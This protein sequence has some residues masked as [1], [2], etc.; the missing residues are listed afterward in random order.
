MKLTTRGFTQ[1]KVA[2][3]LIEL[4]VVVLIIGILAAVALPQYQKA[5][6]KSRITE[7]VLF[8]HEI[9]HACQ[10][11]ELAGNDCV[12]NHLLENMDIQLP[13]EPTTEDCY[14]VMCINTKDWQY[15]DVTGGD[16]TANRVV[17]G[18]WENPLY[19]L[20]IQVLSQNQGEP[21]YGKIQCT[22]GTTS[23]C[24][25]LCGGDGCLID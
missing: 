22:N 13:G 16:F 14:D 11:Y 23:F 25:K 10:L 12:D 20:N 5:V 9:H 19:N 6:E 24:D 3:T 4:L 21:T 7:A 17:N 1:N 8:L 15:V 2:F 18:D